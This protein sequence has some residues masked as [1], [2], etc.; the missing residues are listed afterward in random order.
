MAAENTARTAGLPLAIEL[1]VS[2]QRGLLGEVRPQLRQASIEADEVAQ[3]IRIRFEYDGA[4]EADAQEGCACAASEV[5]ADFP[6]PWQ[7][8]EE[9]VSVPCPQRLSRLRHLAYLRAEPGTDG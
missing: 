1:L 3:L 2:L 6:A 5:I 4:P 8:H 7:L 9:H